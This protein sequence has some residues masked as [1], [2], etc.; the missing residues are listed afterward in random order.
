MKKLVKYAGPPLEVTVGQRVLLVPLDH[1][2]ELVQN[3]VSALTTQVEAVY[4]SGVFETKN[5]RYTPAGDNH[6]RD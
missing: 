3:G 5:T 4:G 1:T 2:S 6:V